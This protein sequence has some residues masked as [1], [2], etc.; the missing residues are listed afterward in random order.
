MDLAIRALVR[1]ARHTY[2]QHGHVLQRVT[3]VK[4]KPSIRLPVIIGDYAYIPAP[5]SLQ[6]RFSLL[7]RSL[8]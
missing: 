8:R 3:G 4:H 2:R 5:N 6:R 1:D 7:P